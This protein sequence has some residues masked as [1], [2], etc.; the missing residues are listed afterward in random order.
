MAVQRA[1]K[2]YPMIKWF[3]ALAVVVLVIGVMMSKVLTGGGEDDNQAVLFIAVGV[4]I[5]LPFLAMAFPR[6]EVVT[7]ALPTDTLAGRPKAELEAILAGLDEAKAK[8]EMDEARYSNA[9]AK[10]VAAMKK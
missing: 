3:V 9:R 7:M 6:R 2:S 1:V 5:A 4:A 10:V 8:G